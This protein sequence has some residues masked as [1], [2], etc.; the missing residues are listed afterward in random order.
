MQHTLDPVGRRVRTL[1]LQHALSQAELAERAGVA[2]STLL[3][4]EAGHPSHPRTVRKIA[5]ALG[6]RPT[7]L[8]IG[9]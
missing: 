2:R 4:I 8:T 7:A 1:R 5:S 6:V 9:Q 3:K